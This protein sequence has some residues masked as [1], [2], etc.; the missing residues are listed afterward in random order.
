V[1]FP[2]GPALVDRL[3]ATEPGSNERFPASARAG[4]EGTRPPPRRLQST[5][6]RRITKTTLACGVH[7]RDIG[8]DEAVD[9]LAECL[10]GG[11]AS[12][13]FRIATDLWKM[14]AER[15]VPALARCMETRR[16]ELDDSARGAVQMRTLARMARPRGG[17][18]S[19]GG[20]Y[21]S[22]PLDKDGCGHRPSQRPRPLR[23]VR[24]SSG[25]SPSNVRSTDGTRLRR[26]WRS[27]AGGLP[28][29]M[30]S[31]PTM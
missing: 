29:P 24:P 19:R 25:P 14:R 16:E 4:K 28:R 6:T 5:C 26:S 7:M 15:A 2:D 10:G 30:L 17:A 8:S 18:G 31:L 27:G 22:P 3:S 20:L 13:T 21:G 23:R 12:L 9:K 11:S 1:R